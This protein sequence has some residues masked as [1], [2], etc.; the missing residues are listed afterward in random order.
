MSVDSDIVKCIKAEDPR[1]LLRW[2]VT[3]FALQFGKLGGN[4]MRYLKLRNL[5]K[6]N[7]TVSKLL[8]TDEIIS[9][10]F[11]NEERINKLTPFVESLVDAVGSFRFIG[12]EEG[13]MELVEALEAIGEL[14]V[15]DLI[16]IRQ[17]LG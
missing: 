2:V 8:T 10:F 12:D 14:D 4:S 1:N 6:W 3:H 7:R 9:V 17:L 11:N 16:L 13:V 5:P 15:V